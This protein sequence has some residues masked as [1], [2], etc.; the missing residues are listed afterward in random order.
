MSEPTLY[1]RVRKWTDDVGIDDPMRELCCMME[2]YG[3]IDEAD[4]SQ[5]RVALADAI[6]DSA[7]CLISNDYLLRKKQGPFIED[8]VLLIDDPKHLTNMALLGRVAEGCRKPKKNQQALDIQVIMLN[9]LK[10]YATYMGLD[11]HVDCLGPVVDIIEARVASG[12]LV[13]GTFV[14]AVD[15]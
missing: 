13:N 9:R 4:H 12:R 7:V 3:E 2:E 1:D 14:K 8:Q 15:L 11:F 6:G 10:N 5:D